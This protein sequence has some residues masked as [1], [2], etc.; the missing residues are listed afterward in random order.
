MAGR[1]SSLLRLKGRQKHALGTT[2]HR[3]SFRLEADKIQAYQ[4]SAALRS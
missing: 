3:D 2:I 1:V 4:A